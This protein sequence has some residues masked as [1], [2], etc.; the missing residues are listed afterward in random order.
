MR[1]SREKGT[2]LVEMA[3]LFPLG[4]LLLL[5]AIQFGWAFY[6]Y[7]Q[8]EKAVRDAARYAAMRTHYDTTAFTTQVRNVAVCG[9]PD[10]TGQTPLVPNLT[11][12]Q[13]SWSFT[14]SSSASAKPDTVVVW[15]NDYTFPRVLMPLRI[16]QSTVQPSQAVRLKSAFPYMG[17]FVIYP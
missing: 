14:W 13:I 4:A 2:A 8:L 11:P 3:L 9:L 5:G 12:T 7:N 15:V 16:Q 10:C 17:R 1:N 6:I